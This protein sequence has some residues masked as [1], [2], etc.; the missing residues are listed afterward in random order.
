MGFIS[1]R[2]MLWATAPLTA[3]SAAALFAGCSINPQPL[4]PDQPDAT[5]GGYS[6]A[7][8]QPTLGDSGYDVAANPK[9]GEGGLEA[10]VDVGAGGGDGGPPSE[11]GEEAG[12]EA[13]G[14]AEADAAT[15]AGSTDAASADAGAVDGG[16]P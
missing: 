8:A 11:A 13:G 2:G 10:S 7:D 4:P 12:V 1:A 15:D 3:L 5:N 6:F 9:P 14:D 16:S